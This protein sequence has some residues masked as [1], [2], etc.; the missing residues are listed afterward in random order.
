MVKV[1]EDLTGMTFG[2]LTVIKQVEDYVEPLSGKHHAQWLCQCSCEAHSL[3]VVQG[4]RLKKNNGTRSCGCLRR[5]GLIQ[6]NQATKKKYNTFEKRC[7]ENG[8]Y[9]VGWTT[10]TN[11]E[12]YFD[13][14]DYNKVKEY[15]WRETTTNNGK[16]HGL[17]ARDKN[18]NNT[19]LMSWL[20]K[21]KYYDH[22]DR[23]PLNNRRYNL[24][25]Y[26][27]SQNSQNRTIGSNNTSGIIG[28]RY[29]KDS[30]KWRATIKLNY[31]V[32]S[33]GTFVNKVD[34]IKAR[35]YAE[36]EL[37][38]EFSPQKHLFEQYGI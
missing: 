28:V 24:R 25:K 23:N 3:V 22:A 36:K 11:K 35:L 9:Y 10:N 19:I 6:N 29:R 38:G 37:F 33:L 15:A 21:G 31:K 7:D 13:T 16:Y 30:Q 14:E 27:Y 34:A 5:E 2:R 4:S 12:F 1:K 26:T 8:E 32:K 20:I 18:T 17:A